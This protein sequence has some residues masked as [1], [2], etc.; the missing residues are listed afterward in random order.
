[1]S[2]EIVPGPVKPVTQRINY[3][4]LLALAIM[5]GSIAVVIH[6][7]FGL[8]DGM[9]NKILDHWP[10]IAGMVTGGVTSAWSFL[11]GPVLHVTDKP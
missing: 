10:I 11:L 6:G 2:N 5:V 4:A 9:Q 1:M 8:S 7:Y 3:T